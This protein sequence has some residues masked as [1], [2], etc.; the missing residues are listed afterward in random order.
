MSRS[1]LLEALGAASKATLIGVTQ[2]RIP[3]LETI[4]PSKKWGSNRKERL[5]KNVWSKYSAHEN[6]T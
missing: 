5:K 4:F 1:G 6:R 3:A 2:V